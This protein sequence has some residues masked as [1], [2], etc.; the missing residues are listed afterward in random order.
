[1]QLGDHISQALSLVGIT[2]DRVSQW[3][4]NCRCLERREKLNWLGSWSKQVLKGK[5][6]GMKAWLERGMMET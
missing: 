4:G 6:E 1:M 5:I 2:E 3:L